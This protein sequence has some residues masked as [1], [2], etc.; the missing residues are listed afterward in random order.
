MVNTLNGDPVLRERCQIWQFLYRSSSPVAISAAELRQELSATIQKLDPGG[1]DAALRQMVV[2]GHSQGGLL[3]KMTAI[4]TGDQLWSVLS[5][6]PLAESNYTEAEREQIRSYLFMK[7]LPFVRRV[8]FSCTPHRG[9][10]Q[11][12]DLV[13]N[14]ARKLVLLPETMVERSAD[15]LRKDK[16]IKLPAAFRR[17]TL[18]SVDAMS[19]ANP[20]LLK[21]A[22]MPVAPPIKA[23]SII[24][25]KGVDQPPAGGDGVVRYNSAHVSYTETE[26]IVR[27]GHSC[28]D[29]P[30]TIEEVRRILREHLKALPTTGPPTNP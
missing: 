27:S 17:K 22:E 30:A 8:V 24:A 29:K 5:K 26:L 11:A 16:D 10:S 2:I 19:P 6:K 4:D 25:I 7:P 12:G 28:Q 21:L 23:N 1:Q 13:R 18:T 3:A 14:L 20:L 9:S 15:L